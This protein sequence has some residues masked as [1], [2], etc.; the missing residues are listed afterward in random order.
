MSERILQRHLKRNIQSEFDVI[1]FYLNNLD[2]LNY[3]KNKKKIDTLVFDSFKHA[4]KI[5]KVLLARKREDKG[6][7]EKARKVALKEECDVREIYRYQLMKHKDKEVMKL[8]HDLIIDES[9]HE[10]TVRALK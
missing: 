4:M 10:K 3:N 7:S 1:N 9:E 8:L 2:K 6:L 5:S